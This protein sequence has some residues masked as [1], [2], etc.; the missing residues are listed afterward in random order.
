[1]ITK[2]VAAKIYH[3]YNQIEQG[4]KMIDE[5]KKSINEQGE[6]ELSE[7]WT[8]QKRGLELHIPSGR[9][10]GSYSIKRV[11]LEVGLNTIKIHIEDSKKELDQLK[12]LCETQLA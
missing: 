11:P 5:L 10:G 8:G 12:T 9:G 4:E 1:M 3:C 6:F 7:D 2:E